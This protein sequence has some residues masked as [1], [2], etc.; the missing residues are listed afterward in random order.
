[1]SCYDFE[2]SQISAQDTFEPSRVII[3]CSTFSF[4]NRRDYFTA[5]MMF[6][7][8]NGLAPLRLINELNAISDAYSAN[9]QA[10]SNGNI[11]VPMP[12]VE[13]FRIFFSNIEV[14]SYGTH[15]HVIYAEQR[16]LMNF[17]D[18]TMVISTVFLK[19]FVTPTWQCVTP[20]VYCLI[21]GLV[22]DVCAWNV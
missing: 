16:I 10:S 5:T 20:P 17:Y 6:K 3:S 14:Q 2:N 11:L 12:H 21:F 22:K 15:C 8:I 7:C 13:Q 1:M 4:D 18:A 9:T 19:H